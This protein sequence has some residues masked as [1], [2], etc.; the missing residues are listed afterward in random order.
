M[1]PFSVC[2][3][4]LSEHV[5]KNV[6]KIVT[7]LNCEEHAWKNSLVLKIMLVRTYCDLWCQ[8]REFSEVIFE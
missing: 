1:L 3:I 4:V 6:R 5:R 7:Q 8:V 2:G